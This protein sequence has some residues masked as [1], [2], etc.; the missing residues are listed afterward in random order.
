LRPNLRVFAASPQHLLGLSMRMNMSA[1]ARLHATAAW[2]KPSPAT[3]EIENDRAFE[4]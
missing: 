3:S 4:V 1:P 2:T